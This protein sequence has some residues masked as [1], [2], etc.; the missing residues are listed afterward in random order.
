MGRQI[1]KPSA[2]LVAAA[3]I[4]AAAL[5]DG[6][7][8]DN[9]IAADV[10]C[11]HAKLSIFLVQ[12]GICKYVFASDINEGPLDKARQN[13]QRRTLKDKP[14]AEYISLKLCDGLEE[15]SKLN[16]VFILGMG[17]EVIAGILERAQFL[18]KEENKGRIKLILQPMTSE[19][20]LRE[21]LCANGYNILDEV[22]VL[23]K[24]RVYAVMSVCFD[25]IKRSFTPAELL[26]GKAN[27]QK[28]GELFLRQLERR[29]RICRSEIEQ[30]QRAGLDCTKQNELL[31]E[32]EKL[33]G[34]KT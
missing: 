8:T 28:V 15:N 29:I 31:C 13:I 16:R 25:G 2:R 19:D 30:R 11:D 17:G 14:L 32:M 6:E 12:S 22:M 34:Q 18:R 1:T 26:L 7:D 4:A 24:E 10:G 3:Q 23:D 9:L 20:R 33:N 27:I 5:Y 21:Y